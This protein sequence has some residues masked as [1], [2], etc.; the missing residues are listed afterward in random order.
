MTPP[1]TKQQEEQLY[2]IFYVQGFLFGRDKLYKKSVELNFNISRRQVAE[3][4]K[5][6]EINQ[7]FRPTKLA[8]KTQPTVLNDIH[9]QIGVD[10][11]DFRNKENEENR[12]ILTAID[13]FSKK[14]YAQPLPNKTNKAVVSGMKTILDNIDNDISSIRSDNGS[15]F[16]SKE[17]KKLLQDRNIKQVFSLPHT[18]QSNGQVERFNGII[19]RLIRQFLY[20]NNS[21]DWVKN[22]QTLV[23]NYNSSYQETIK[24]TPNNVEEADEDKKTV[25]KDNIYKAVAGKLQK[26]IIP[27]EVVN[28]TVR[29]KHDETPWSSKIYTIEKVFKPKDNIGKTYFKLHGLKKKF[30]YN[31]IQIIGDIQ[32]SIDTPEKYEV[33]KLV[34]PSVVEGVPGYY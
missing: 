1:I 17:F 4:L 28:K 31:D 15:E 21:Y 30:Y 34:R 8:T 22:L 20:I 19:K 32:N 18:P 16:I 29:I 12:W 2:N 26:D 23:D 27:K 10:L 11:I 7:I 5:K 25:V 14:A 9:K 33:S 13:L 3:W 6:Q 24:D